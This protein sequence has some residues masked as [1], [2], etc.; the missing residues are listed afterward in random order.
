MTFARIIATGSYL[1]T[2]VVSNFDLEKT[3]NTSDEWIAKRTGIRNRHIVSDQETTT[4]M[5]AKAAESALE[6]VN[7]T[8][9]DID[10]VLVAT[11][12]AEQ[13]F[14]ST[15]CQIAEKINLLPCIA[16]D[17]Q[18]A[19]S[20]FIYAL[21]VASQYIQTGQVKTALV[22]GSESMS[23]VMDWEDRTTCVLFGDGAGCV[24]LEASQEPGIFST[25]LK[26]DGRHKD[27]LYLN[28]AMMADDGYL[29]MDGRPV[30][31]SAVKC[32]E[33]IALEAIEYNKF[34]IQDIDWI[35][36]HQANIRII[37]ST[38]KKLGISMDKVILTV[39]EHAN[40]SGAS[41]PM[42]LD[43]AVNDGRIQPGQN[44]LLEA[45]GGGLTWGSALVRY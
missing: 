3:I 25:H 21:S 45:F 4:L 44:L 5:G 6:K 14:P 26:A 20:G 37:K 11:C 33:E 1:P 2:K 15:A 7:L 16:F 10:L 31:R 40:T 28:N 34:Q 29:R 32:L 35:V 18:A 39:Q 12:T 23:R 8:T 38:A 41:I 42:A 19:C 9:E 30:F 17:V 22:I 13:I 24:L 36:P 43:I 27:I